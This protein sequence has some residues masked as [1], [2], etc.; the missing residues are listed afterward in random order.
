MVAGNGNYALG[1]PVQPWVPQGAFFRPGARMKGGETMARGRN[2]PPSPEAWAAVM[3]GLLGLCAAGVGV[4]YFLGALSGR[5]LFWI[6]LLIGLAA[7][8]VLRRY[9]TTPRRGS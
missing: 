5:Q 9:L 2:H 8:S 3:G 6:I 4:M 1:E 7:L